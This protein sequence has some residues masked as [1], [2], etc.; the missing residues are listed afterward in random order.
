[1]TPMVFCSSEV[2][3]DSAIM[4]AE[5]VWAL[6][7]HPMVLSSSSRTR[8]WGGLAATGVLTCW[9][10]VPTAAEIAQSSISSQTA[11]SSCSSQSAP[12]SAMAQFVQV[13]IG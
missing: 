3:C 7:N 5:T 11:C 13:P 9:R 6:R 1:M 4:D 12:G 2:P 10:G 8:A